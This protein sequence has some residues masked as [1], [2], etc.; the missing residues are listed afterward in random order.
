MSNCPLRPSIGYLGLLWWEWQLGCDFWCGFAAFPPHPTPAHPTPHCPMLL[1]TEKS[2]LKVATC[3]FSNFLHL[4]LPISVPSSQETPNH[5]P[6]VSNSFSFICPFIY[7]LANKWKLGT[8]YMPRI[9]QDIQIEWGGKIVFLSE[10]CRLSEDTEK[11][12]VTPDIQI[13]FQKRPWHQC[14]K[15]HE[16]NSLRSCY[17]V[18]CAGLVG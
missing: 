18:V 9:K 10:A 16:C 13:S 6:T 7:P 17:W 1:I 5:P 12:Y 2:S 15:G 4:Q 8:Y 14:S 3:L 11:D